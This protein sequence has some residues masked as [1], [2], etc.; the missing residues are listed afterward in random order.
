[1]FGNLVQSNGIK[2][3]FLIQSKC[4]IEQTLAC[5]FTYLG[6]DSPSIVTFSQY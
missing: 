4:H 1:M 6:L 5:K 2:R 3:L